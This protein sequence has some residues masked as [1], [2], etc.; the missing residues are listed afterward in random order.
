MK[1]ISKGLKSALE[2][3]V[4]AGWA[5]IAEQQRLVHQVEDLEHRL[6]N[7]ETECR[8]LR[9]V[10]TILLRNEGIPIEASR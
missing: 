7:V 2:Q 1:W 10:Q 6:R 4:I 8:S 5:A 9:K 3:L